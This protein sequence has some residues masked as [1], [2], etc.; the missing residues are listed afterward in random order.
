MSQFIHYH[1]WSSWTI[2]QHLI[3]DN[4]ISFCAE[5][6]RKIA[7]NTFQQSRKNYDMLSKLNEMLV[8]DVVSH[9]YQIN[10][11]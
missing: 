11:S 8:S 1:H 3:C 10:C 9:M 7:Q 5:I 6:F 4:S 2:V